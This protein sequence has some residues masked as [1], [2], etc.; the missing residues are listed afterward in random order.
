MLK[1]I[2]C[3]R[4]PSRHTHLPCLQPESRC[5]GES[6]APNRAA[7]RQRRP[8]AIGSAWRRS[9]RKSVHYGGSHFLQVRFG[10]RPA[11]ISQRKPSAWLPVPP[12]WSEPGCGS[13]HGIAEDSMGESDLSVCVD[14]SPPAAAAMSGYEAMCPSCYERQRSPEE[15]VATPSW[16]G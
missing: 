7:Q 14:K 3:L 9:C 6:G 13:E 8:N 2:S 15:L 10:G 5:A 12:A 16:L 1:P 11:T 4:V